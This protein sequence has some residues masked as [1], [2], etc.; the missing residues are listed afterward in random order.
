MLLKKSKE[1][2]DYL[3]KNGTFPETN[4]TSS[5]NQ[6]ENLKPSNLNNEEVNTSSDRVMDNRPIRT[7]YKEEDFTSTSPSPRRYT[8]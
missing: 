8:Y 7:V 1:E 5:S 2:L 6:T 3:V 4:S